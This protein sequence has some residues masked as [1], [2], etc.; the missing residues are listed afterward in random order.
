MKEEEIYGTVDELLLQWPDD[1]ISSD[2]IVK[3]EA[4]LWQR[5]WIST[6]EKPK[7][8]IESLNI[9]NQSLFPNIYYMLKTCA[10]IPVTVAT[11]E[12][13][14]PT[15]KRVKTYTRNTMEENRLN[16]L[17]MLSIHRD[18]ETDTE[19]VIRDFDKKKTEESICSWL[20]FRYIIY[21]K[22]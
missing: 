19:E 7:N 21:N 15:L 20:I 16:E 10:T 2:I 6:D 8:F 5:K 13:Y 18:I 9:C 4:L 3:K 12:R 11:A 22:I 17:V 1:S 14:F